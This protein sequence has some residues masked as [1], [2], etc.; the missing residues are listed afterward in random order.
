MCWHRRRSWSVRR[1]DAACPKSTWSQATKPLEIVR[2]RK[3]DVSPHWISTIF[4]SPLITDISL[5]WGGLVNQKISEGRN[6]APHSGQS[7]VNHITYI[8][9]EWL[10][11]LYCWTD[12]M[13]GYIGWIGWMNEWMNRGRKCD[14]LINWTDSSDC[15]D[16]KVLGHPQLKKRGSHQQNEP[17]GT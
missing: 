2:S 3:G 6:S 13:Y 7:F 10:K 5:L 17:Q 12:W 4:R 9:W 8:T 14:K 1:G 11:G 16:C 15:N